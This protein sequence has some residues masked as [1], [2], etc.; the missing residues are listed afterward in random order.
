MDISELLNDDANGSDWE[1]ETSDTEEV[2][3]GDIAITSNE[4]HE[5]ATES[6]NELVPSTQELMLVSRRTGSAYIDGII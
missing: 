3:N 4:E 6:E 5:V 1:F 2:E